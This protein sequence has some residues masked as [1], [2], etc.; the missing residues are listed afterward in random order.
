M[1][2][3]I[4]L[5]IGLMF[6]VSS[7]AQTTVID[8]PKIEKD[9]TGQVVVIMTMEQAQKLDNAGDLLVLFE[10]MN[11][12]LGSY[13]DACVKVVNEQQQVIATQKIQISELKSQ[14]DI[15]AKEIL[16]LQEQIENYKKDLADCDKQ[17]VNKDKIISEQKD[18]I[19]KQKTK[20]V[21][22]GS[23]GGAAII[24]L[25]ILLIL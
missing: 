21:L 6:T 3:L 10:K 16:N 15:K 8:Y 12:Q 4:G 11:A 19:K 20:M 23:L 18:T 1:K 25:T 2:Y 13:D 5:F 9:S 14:V 22:G 17:S 7:F 24:V